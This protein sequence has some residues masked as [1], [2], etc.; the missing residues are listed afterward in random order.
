MVD[1]Y[2]DGC[3]PDTGLCKSGGERFSSATLAECIEACR[4]YVGAEKDGMSFDPDNPNCLQIQ[5]TETDD[6]LA[7]SEHDIDRWTKGECQ[8]WLACYSFFIVR[9][10]TEPVPKLPGVSNA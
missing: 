2:S 3:D 4:E 10:I 9:V 6:G 1:T 5:V 8:L 7:A